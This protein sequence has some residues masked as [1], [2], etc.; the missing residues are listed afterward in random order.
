MAAAMV[1]VSMAVVPTT[2]S[3]MVVVLISV[4]V[5]GPVRFVR[6]IR[7]V[8][9]IRLPRLVRIRRL[10]RIS[11]L[12]R[13]R[14]LDRLRRLNWLRLNLRRIYLRGLSLHWLS[15]LRRVPVFVSVVAP[16]QHSD[17]TDRRCPWSNI[18]RREQRHEPNC[19]YNPHLFLLRF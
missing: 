17:R 19:N 3:A 9:T 6:A 4:A 14:G 15:Y 16:I 7:S 5:A 2:R 18:T 10:R 11:R 12:H 1:T 8:R 13:V